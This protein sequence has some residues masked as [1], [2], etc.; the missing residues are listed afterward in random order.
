MGHFEDRLERKMANPEF[1]TGYREALLEATSLEI[2]A[3]SGVELT[4]VT[5]MEPEV[6]MQ[7]SWA[8]PVHT[9]VYIA[10]GQSS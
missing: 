10:C 5:T 8:A 1:A 7:L 4:S 3:G 2:T 6:S 9:Q